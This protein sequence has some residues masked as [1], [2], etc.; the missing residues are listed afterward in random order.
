MLPVVGARVR[1]VDDQLEGLVTEGLEG[2]NDVIDEKVPVRLA[3]FVATGNV[4]EDW[5]AGSGCSRL[6]SS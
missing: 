1:E 3:D 2:E 4:V 5:I 6:K